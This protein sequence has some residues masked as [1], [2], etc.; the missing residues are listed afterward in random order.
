[1][2]VSVLL[3]VDGLTVCSFTGPGIVYIQ[4]RNPETLGSWIAEQVPLPKSTSGRSA[5]GWAD[6]L[7][8]AT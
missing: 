2:T 5:L 7:D 3:S 6:V 4:T 8:A 1:M